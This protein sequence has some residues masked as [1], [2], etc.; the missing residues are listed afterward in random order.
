M[1]PDFISDDIKSNAEKKIFSLIKNSI[2]INQV[3]ALHSL[4]IANHINNVF[5]EIDF[6]I[7]CPD[8]FL[9][10]EIKGGSIHRE[11]GIWKFTNRYNKT[12]EKATGPFAQV[13][14]NMHSLRK[15]II[16]RL[17]G[18]SPLAKA[19]FACCVVMPDCIFDKSGID[20]IPEIIFDKR[21][22]LSLESMITVSFDYWKRQI[23]TKHGFTGSELNYGDMNFALQILR[24]DFKIM[25]SLRS[26][27]DQTERELLIL[28][29]E[30]YSILEAFENNPRLLIS[31]MAGTG[32]TLLA[33]EQCRRMYWSGKRV[34]Y[35]CYN[36]NICR[37]VQTIFDRESVEVTASTFHALLM[38]LCTIKWSENF[39]D[40][41]FETELPGKFLL[42][43]ISSS[44]KYDVIVIDEGQDLFKK[45][46]FNCL[47]RLL[48]NGFEKGF[49]SIYFDPNQNIYNDAI[50]TEGVLKEC[51][52]LAFNYKLSI[53]C[54]NT[55]QIVNANIL[56]TNIKQALRSKANGID[57]EYI[58]YSDLQQEF[59]FLNNKLF[60]IVNGG[61]NPNEIVLLSPYK[62]DN[63]NCCLS[64]GIL[65]ASL[66]VLHADGKIWNMKQNEIG[67]STIYSFKGLESKIVCLLDVSSFIDHKNR[68]LT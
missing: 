7:I 37:Y 49:W 17:G 3:I 47:D 50:E 48:K 45:I 59:V 68:L 66:G 43:N 9:C 24:G 29:D 5:G 16:K 38:N 8:G 26:V 27:V 20:I 51:E 42:Q 58:S 41:F 28:T 11:N 44:K 40:K 12:E 1:V 56:T 33:I 14:G 46:Y 54:R 52:I 2:S 55:K 4:G 63:K 6:V 30:Q 35:L 32:K 62:H 64:R 25:P 57:V 23:S 15:Y 10:I 65:P 34:L 21:N 19:Q 67:F 22:E 61:I 31:G 53:N 36:N 60:E 13:Q 39:D 18:D